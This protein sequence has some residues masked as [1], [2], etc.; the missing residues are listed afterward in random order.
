M[1]AKL[2]RYHFCLI[3]AI[4]SWT[5][6]DQEP[7]ST[8]RPQT[9]SPLGLTSVKTPGSKNGQGKISCTEPYASHS[10]LPASNNLTLVVIDSENPCK[11]QGHFL[12]ARWCGAPMLQLYGVATQPH[13]PLQLEESH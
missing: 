7:V 6:E 4:F 3:K 1:R 13:G 10:P 5:T 12:W 2:V 11:N 9:H 8:D